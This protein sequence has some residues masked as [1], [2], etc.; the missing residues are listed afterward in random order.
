MAVEEEVLCLGSVRRV[1]VDGVERSDVVCATRCKGVLC[2]VK[3]CRVWDG[4]SSIVVSLVKE[5]GAMMHLMK[6]DDW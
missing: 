4:I 2:W 6:S 3:C 5:D 1:S